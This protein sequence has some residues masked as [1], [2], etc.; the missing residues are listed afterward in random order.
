MK[1]N[2]KTRTGLVAFIIVFIVS[3]GWS[4]CKKDNQKY[5]FEVG[6]INISIDPNS[7]RYQELNTVGGWLYL[8]FYDGIDPPSR[9]VIVHR[10]D[11][12]RFVAFERTPVYE[13]NA[14]CDNTGVCTHL[15]VD[16]PF[17]E[18]TCSDS[19][20]LLLDGSVIEGPSTLPLLQYAAEYDGFV[21]HIH[22]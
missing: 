19:R 16:Y 2:F 21:L 18:D 20:F 10:A 3:A 1:M 13:P 12:D 4:G 17:V 5:P 14:C 8:G 22:N 7:A 9:G 15:I 11:L 6:N